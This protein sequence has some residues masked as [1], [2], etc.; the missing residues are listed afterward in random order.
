MPKFP[1][2]KPGSLTPLADHRA[3]PVLGNWQT[4]NADETSVFVAGLQALGLAPNLD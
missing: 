3:K 4:D 1:D 2:A